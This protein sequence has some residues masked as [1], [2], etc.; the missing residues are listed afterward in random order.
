[1]AAHRHGFFCNLCLLFL[2]SALAAQTVIDIGRFEEDARIS[3]FLPTG[4]LGRSVAAGEINGDGVDD[5]LGGAEV[6]D[7]F[8]LAAGGAFL[9]LGSAVLPRLIDLEKPYRRVVFWGN[10]PQDYTG[11]FLELFDFSGDGLADVFISAP[12][13]NYAG[14]NLVSLKSNLCR[15]SKD[16]NRQDAK[17]AKEKNFLPDVL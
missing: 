15:E 3:N 7:R 8:Y 16:L 14:G 10:G 11:D 6:I 1:M 2:P 13:W 9:I 17:F 12:Q 4:G 5:V